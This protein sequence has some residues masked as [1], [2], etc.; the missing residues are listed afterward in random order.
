MLYRL[1]LILCFALSAG[2]GEKLLKP[3]PTGGAGQPVNGLRAS[4]AFVK[5]DFGPGESLLLNWKLTNESNAPVEIDL[6]KKRLMDFSFEIR[7]DGKK[8]ELRRASDAERQY[9]PGSVSID[10]GKS[11]TQM[12][13]LSSLD[14]TDAAWTRAFG[15]YEVAVTY[16]PRKIQSGFATFRVTAPGEIREPVAPEVAE[17]VRTLIGQLGDAEFATREQAHKQLLAIGKPALGLLEETIAAGGDAEVVAR[18]RRLVA[19]IRGVLPPLPPPIPQPIR[20]PPPL[21]RPL[22]PPPVTPPPPPAPP[23]PGPAPRPDPGEF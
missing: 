10:A 20:P 8:L 7:R 6:D 11:I 12:I 19:E 22:L 9:T 3:I 18:A 21:P 23:L 2:A 4:V 17:K 13:D 16:N 5:N 1:S 14:W 15:N